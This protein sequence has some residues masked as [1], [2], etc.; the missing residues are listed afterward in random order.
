MSGRARLVSAVRS[1]TKRQSEE[2]ATVVQLANV[3]ET[4]PDF[5][6]ELLEAD[7]LIR[8]PLMTQWVR[9]YHATDTIDID[10]TVV[11]VKRSGSWIITD[12]LS[13]KEPS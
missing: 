10:D 3:V 7:I 11:V 4:E 9:K 13:D 5:V 8:E 2:A 12:V 1:H 6:L